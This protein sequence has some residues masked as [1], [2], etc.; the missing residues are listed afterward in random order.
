MNN[1][2]RCDMCSCYL[3]PGEGMLCDECRQKLRERERMADRMREAVRESD[4]GKIEM[5]FQEVG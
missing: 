4:G 1:C 2:Y 5:R 3:D